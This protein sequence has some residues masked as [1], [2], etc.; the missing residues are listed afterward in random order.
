MKLDRLAGHRGLAFLI[1]HNAKTAA[2]IEG[3]ARSGTPGFGL[4]FCKS[5][6]AAFAAL[7]IE[8]FPAWGIGP[9][10]G[11]FR[12]HWGMRSELE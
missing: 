9:C 6:A 11:V 8:T 7:P 1:R 4:A 2:P 10:G 5:H 12:T 3:V